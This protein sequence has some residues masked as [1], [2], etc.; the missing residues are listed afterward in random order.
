MSCSLGLIFLQGKLGTWKLLIG[1][2]VGGTT[3]MSH[4]RT[5][6]KGSRQGRCGLILHDLFLMELCARFAKMGLV[7]KEGWSWDHANVFTTQ[8]A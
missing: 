4:P 3:R 2:N 6:F 7:Q 5:T 1:P 8:C